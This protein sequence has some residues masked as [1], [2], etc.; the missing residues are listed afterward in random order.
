MTNS[1]KCFYEWLADRSFGWAVRRKNRW[2]QVR[3][4]PDTLTASRILMPLVV[5]GILRSLGQGH[6]AVA[7]LLVIMV[8]V[9]F[10]TDAI[11]GPLARKMGIAD[12]WFG[13]LFDATADK[14]AIDFS[15]IVLWHSA[16]LPLH[17][18]LVLLIVVRIALD[19]ALFLASVVGAL[20]HYAPGASNMGKIKFHF[21]TG[22][23]FVLSLANFW[24][25]QAR[26]GVL[27]GIGMSALGIAC[28]YS[29]LS[30]IH[31]LGLRKERTPHVANIPA[32]TSSSR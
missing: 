28:G 22:A 23:V 15:L 3:F 30:L 2:P 6:D 14:L 21:D 20:R 10:L 1:L 5:L 9:L 26:A 12:R 18:V 13:K 25:G 19:V 4:L 32:G 24:P 31:H 8:V 29:V 16:I 11:D 27:R 7:A 17:G